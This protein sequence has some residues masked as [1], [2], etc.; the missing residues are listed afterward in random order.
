MFF[1]QTQTVV[2]ARVLQVMEARQE[3]E[4]PWSSARMYFRQVSLVGRREAPDQE[5]QRDT[6]VAGREECERPV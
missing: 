5:F 2:A 1:G 4:H 6:L 3:L